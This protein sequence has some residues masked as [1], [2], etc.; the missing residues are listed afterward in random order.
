MFYLK[1]ELKN[2]TDKIIGKVKETTGKILDDDE[3]ELKGK[4]QSIK[5]NIG[6][7]LEDMKEEVLE[8][9]NDLIDKVKENRKDK[10]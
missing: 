6:S 10:D 7:K 2:G 1:N 9:T 8:K 5:A 3:L 4:L